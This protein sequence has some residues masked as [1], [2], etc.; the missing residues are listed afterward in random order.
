MIDRD[1]GTVKQN[2]DNMEKTGDHNGVLQ[3]GSRRSKKD[4]TQ[5][6]YKCGCAKTYLSYP[7][8][9]THIKNKHNGSPPEGTILGAPS[10]DPGLKGDQSEINANSEV[11]LS[12]RDL[13]LEEQSQSAVESE[14]NRVDFQL[15][16]KGRS[17]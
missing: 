7:A 1:Y 17:G 10:N 5:R 2:W 4:N 15:R 12:R 3:K 13:D 16:R 8:L 14:L 11:R 6:H 9:Y